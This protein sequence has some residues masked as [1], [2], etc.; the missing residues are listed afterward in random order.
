M[1][2]VPRG[3]GGGE[4]RRQWERRCR[5]CLCHAPA[6]VDRSHAPRDTCRMAAIGM[7]RAARLDPDRPL[8]QSQPPSRGRHRLLRVMV[9]RQ[10]RVEVQQPAGWLLM[11]LHRFAGDG[12]LMAEVRSH[13]GTALV[14]GEPPADRRPAAGPAGRS[15]EQ[16]L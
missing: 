14:V 11:A 9:R 16:M 13:A 5:N 8:P 4:R 1:G 6:A 12:K 7:Q 3:R 15:C 2:A 10:C